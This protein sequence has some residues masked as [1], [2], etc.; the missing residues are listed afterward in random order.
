MSGLAIGII[1]VLLVVGSTFIRSK[2]TV[3]NL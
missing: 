2:V 1:V 3:L